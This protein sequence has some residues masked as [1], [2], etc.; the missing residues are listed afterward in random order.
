LEDFSKTK[1]DIFETLFANQLPSNIQ[2]NFKK[3]FTSEGWEI[4][5]LSENI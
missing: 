2:I 4:A 5:K 3:Y 1:T